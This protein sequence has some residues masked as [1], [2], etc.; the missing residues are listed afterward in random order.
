MVLLV[1]NSKHCFLFAA[2]QEPAS[3]HIQSTMDLPGYSHPSFHSHG[4][5]HCVRCVLALQWKPSETLQGTGFYTGQELKQVT[6]VTKINK[7]FSMS[8]CFFNR[9]SFM[10][11]KKIPVHQIIEAATCVRLGMYVLSE[12]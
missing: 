1:V 12:Y 11:L 7:H 6:I 5:E 3:S 4:V 2:F 10:K 8:V 9:G